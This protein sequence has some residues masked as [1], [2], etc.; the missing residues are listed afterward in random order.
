MVGDIFGHNRARTDKGITAYRMATDNGA[1]GAECCA[2]LDKCGADLVHFTDFRP[3]VID[4]G[5]NHGWTA[6]DAV[7]KGDAFVHGNVVLDLAFIA[8]DSVR[9]DDDIL[10]DV[11][12]FANFGTGKDVGEVPD[13]GFF[14]NGDVVVNDGGGVDGDARKGM[15]TGT[16]TDPFGL[17]VHVPIYIIF[18]DSR[19][20][21]N[22]RVSFFLFDGVLAEF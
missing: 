4:V 7:F 9:T 11:A 13:F 22:D 12:V 20:R 3:W 1:V 14:A 18:L 15:H 19:L 16:H 6:E 5:K 17:P 21:G 8:D 10:A 2:F